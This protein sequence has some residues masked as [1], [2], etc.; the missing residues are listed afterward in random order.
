[1]AI[2]ADPGAAARPF[3]TRRAGRRTRRAVRLRRVG[4][5]ERFASR[6]AGD[7]TRVFSGGDVDLE[8]DGHFKPADSSTATGISSQ[9]ISRTAL[10]G[11]L[12]ARGGL[13]RA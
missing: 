11:G 3:A 13:S 6:R 10:T 4:R 1:M 12:A 7:V 9:S 2:E 8:H 5:E